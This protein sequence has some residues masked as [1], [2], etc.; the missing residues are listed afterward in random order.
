MT[1]GWTFLAWSVPVNGAMIGEPTAVGQAGQFRV[2]SVIDYAS[3]DVERSN[4][5][6]LDSDALRL[7]ITISGLVNQRVEVFG[8]LGGVVIQGMQLPG[9]P[10]FDGEP[11]VAVGGGFKATLYEHG[12]VAW[13]VGGQELYYETHDNGL[14]ATVSWNEVDLFTGPTVTLRPGVD[15]YGGLLGSLVIGDLR[16]PGGSADL[17]QHTPLG[18]FIGGRINVTRSVFFGLELA[19]INELGVS[20]RAGV[21]F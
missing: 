4:L 19:L 9:F 11:D 13:G 15:L 10:D 3:R 2:E 7:L 21:V 5:C 1:A 17:D 8:R 14:S 6:C 12:P 16:G 18:L 20:S